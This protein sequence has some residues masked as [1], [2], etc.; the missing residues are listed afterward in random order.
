MKYL[1]Y[2]FL[3]LLFLTLQVGY[4]GGLWVLFGCLCICYFIGWTFETLK[5][6]ERLSWQA[7]AQGKKK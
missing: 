4:H 1:F 2:T 5:E 7:R 3:V 6:K